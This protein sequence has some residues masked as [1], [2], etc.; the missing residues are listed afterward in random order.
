M[1]TVRI[2]PHAQRQLDR[3]PE[4]LRTRISQRLL[5][6][7]DNPRPRGV[8]KLKGPEGYYALRVGDYRVIY[9]I[10]DDQLAVVIRIRHPRDAYRR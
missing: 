9:D 8:K 6:L 1:Y 3:L 2:V 7:E 5:A 10:Q 4:N